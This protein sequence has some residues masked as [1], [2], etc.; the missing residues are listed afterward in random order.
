MEHR[1]IADVIGQPESWPNTV[2]TIWGGEPDMRGAIIADVV[3]S[4]N[5]IAVYTNGATCGE[6]LSFFVIEDRELMQQ[7]AAALM[8]G[9]E[10][11]AAVAAPLRV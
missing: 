1:T 3:A 7:V 9:S 11:H 8:V 2:D 10:V 4:G 5:E 6:T